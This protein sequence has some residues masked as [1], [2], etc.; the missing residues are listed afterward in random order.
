MRPFIFST[1]AAVLAAIGT[2]FA[3]A[4]LPLEENTWSNPT[5]VAKFTGSYGFD[6]EKNPSITSEEKKLFETIAPIISTDAKQAIATITAA[7]TPTSSAAVDYTLANLYFQAGEGDKA[8]AAY[9]TALKKFPGFVRARQNLGILH[10]QSGRYDAALENLLAA[11]QGGGLNGSLLGLIG[12]SYLNTGKTA[13]ALDA[14]RLALLFEPTSRDWK[15]GKAQC[16]IN[17]GEYKEAITMLDEMIAGT[18]A[19]SNL[20]MLQANAFL[21]DNEPIKAAGNLQTV[22]AMGKA[23]TTSL[24]L[25]G[26]I[27]VNNGNADLAVPYYEEAVKKGELSTDRLVR[28]V[29]ILAGREA[30]AEADKL[31]ATIKTSGSD[32]LSPADK[33]EMLNLEAQVALGTNQD[34]RAAGILEQVVSTDPMNGR[35]MLLLA[36]YHA[37]QGDV[38]KAGLFYERAASVPETEADALVQ[39]ARMLVGQRSFAQAASLLGRAQAV[40]PQANVAS[41]L[42]KVEAAAQASAR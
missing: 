19:D 23:T 13:S 4:V 9:E 1:F 7:L 30:W 40:R 15:I 27:L 5:F 6:S 42:S 8:V 3:S 20:L 22:H 12:F 32:K 11:A 29:K 37:K 25:L 26:D 35:A 41:F 10:V 2:P 28:M 24:V 16:L 34:A 17:V 21:A 33:L 36:D 18:A 31:V 38:D 39:H 14:Y